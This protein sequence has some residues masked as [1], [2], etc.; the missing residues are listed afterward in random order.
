MGT[1]LHVEVSISSGDDSGWAGIPVQIAASNRLKDAMGGSPA[2]ACTIAFLVGALAL[3]LITASGIVGRGSLSG[4]SSAPWW[5]WIGGLLSVTAVLAS[6][7]AL[8]AEGAAG[9]VAFT[10]LGQLVAAMML[11][12]FVWLGVKQNPIN[13]Y[14]ITGAVLLVGGAAL[15]SKN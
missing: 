3:G 6:L 7:L 8:K 2:L 1:H 15:M 12:H 10:V 5:A 9:V 4:A 14:K 13:A 11:D